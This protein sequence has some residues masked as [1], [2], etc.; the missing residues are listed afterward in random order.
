MP[1]FLTLEKINGQGIW[2]NL[3]DKPRTHAVRL[4]PEISAWLKPIVQTHSSKR[5]M[6]YEKQSL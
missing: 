5:S 4:V 1:V 2:K 6:I 3:H